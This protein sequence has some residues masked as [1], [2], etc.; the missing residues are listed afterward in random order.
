MVINFFE[1]DIKP[2]ML[3]LVRSIRLSYVCVLG[4][5]RNVSCSE[6]C[7]YVLNWWPPIVDE[8]LVLIFPRTVQRPIS[9]N[10]DLKCTG[11]WTS[12]PVSFDL[13][14]LHYN[15]L[16]IRLLLLTLYSNKLDLFFYINHKLMDY[17][18]HLK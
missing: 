6:N 18:H 3:L 7:A 5:V 16:F 8:L 2:A 11:L 13:A 15:D 9:I 12:F 1:L 4:V 10:Q 17:L 14:I